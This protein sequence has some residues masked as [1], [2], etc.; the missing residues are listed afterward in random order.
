[1]GARRVTGRVTGR[2]R[3]FVGLGSN[4]GDR[5]GS[6]AAALGRLDAGPDTRVVGVSRVYETEAM[7]LPGAPPQRDHLNAVAEVATTLSPDAL[8]DRLWAIER[9]AGRERSAGR[10]SP[11]P[12]DLDLLLHGDAVRQ[13]E[14][15]TLPHPGLAARRFVLAP[16]AELAPGLVVPGS[17]RTVADLLAACPD[18]LRVTATALRLR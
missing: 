8:L 15:L 10:W 17:G 16:L 14:A 18:A 12:L 13:S 11:R 2:V 7:T 9:A 5:L 1:M 4:V 6:L 3:A